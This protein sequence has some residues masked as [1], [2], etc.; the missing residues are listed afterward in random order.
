MKRKAQI[1]IIIIIGIVLLFIFAGVLVVRP[2]ID[3]RIFKPGILS[4]FRI[5]PE[6]EPDTAA[7]TDHIT[8]MAEILGLV[9]GFAEPASVV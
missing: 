2:D 9:Q 5:L 3:C 6:H 4:V 7:C 8:V 1:T